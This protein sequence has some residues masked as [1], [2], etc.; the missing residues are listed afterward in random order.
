MSLQT[1]HFRTDSEQVAADDPTP[2]SCTVIGRY[3]A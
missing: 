3:S 1:V 2:H